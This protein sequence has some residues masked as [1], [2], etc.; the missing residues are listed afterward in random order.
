MHFVLM[1]GDFAINAVGRQRFV[2]KAGLRLLA[3]CSSTLNL[4]I[5]PDPLLG[6]HV[7]KVRKPVLVLSLAVMFVSSAS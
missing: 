5:N 7:F 3:N 2:M 4:L 6:F 1:A